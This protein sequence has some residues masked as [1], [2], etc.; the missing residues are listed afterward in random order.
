MPKYPDPDKIKKEFKFPRLFMNQ[1]KEFSNEGFVLI[2]ISSD[3]EPII[4]MEADNQLTEMGLISFCSNFFSGVKNFQEAE[5][6]GD[7]IGL[8]D[9][10]G[11]DDPDCPD[12]NED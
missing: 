11:C 12:C 7:V 2:T 9:E 3:G 8:D 5:I 10:S 6:R 4:T 1:L